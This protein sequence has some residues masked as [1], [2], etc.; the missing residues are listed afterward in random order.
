MK[1]L[2]GCWLSIRRQLLYQIL[3]EGEDET[4]AEGRA[5]KVLRGKRGFGD[6]YMISARVPLNIAVSQYRNLTPRHYLRRR[7]EAKPP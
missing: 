3:F 4:G 6:R 1:I 5:I 7:S 2:M